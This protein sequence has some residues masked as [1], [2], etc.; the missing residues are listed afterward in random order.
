MILLVGSI[1]LTV[2]GGT[3][4]YLAGRRNKWAWKI[5]LMNQFLWFTYATLTGQWGFLLGCVV[6][7]SAYVRNGKQHDK[8]A[9]AEVSR[10]EGAAA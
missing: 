5:G 6:Y 3:V 8:D 4:Q 10:Y 7:G 1:I 2:S 9:L